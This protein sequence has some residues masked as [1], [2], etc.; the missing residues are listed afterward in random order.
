MKSN[1]L[2]MRK[3]ALRLKDDVIIDWE[4]SRNP[5]QVAFLSS[6]ADE[7]LYGGQAG[8]AKSESL[9]VGALGDD[10]CG[11]FNKPLWKALLLR[12]TYPELEKSLILRSH[13]LFSG[14]ANYD[15]VKHR[16]TFPLGGIIEFGHIKNEEDK[17]KHKS[18]QYNYIGFDELTE[19]TE[20]MYLYLFSRLR[21]PD[22]SITCYMRGATN[23]TGIGHGWVKKRFISGIEP[24]KIHRIKSLVPDGK[25]GFKEIV[26]TRQFIPSTVF[27]NKYLLN[28]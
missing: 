5:K 18:A 9:L 28:N 16:W 17:Y 23:P 19:F 10:E 14:K 13:Q 3:S 26:L 11:V 1:V 27:Y 12:R 2:K 22:K 7:V 6:P 8:G 4:C 20:G 24:M 15:A 21:T 25:G